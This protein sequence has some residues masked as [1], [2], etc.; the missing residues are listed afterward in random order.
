[1]NWL[2]YLDLSSKDIVIFGYGYFMGYCGS[3]TLVSLFDSLRLSLSLKLNIGFYSYSVGGTLV[4]MALIGSV[5]GSEEREN[6]YLSMFS[7]LG[8]NYYAGLD[9]YFFYIAVAT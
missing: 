1:M 6:G 5:F 8:L 7:P 9:S 4:S 2:F 3:S